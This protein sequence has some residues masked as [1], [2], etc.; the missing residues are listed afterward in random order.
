[1]SDREVAP[2]GAAEPAVAPE[3]SRGVLADVA[4]TIVDVA[5]PVIAAAR[6]VIDERPGARVRRVRRLS[7]QPLANL[8]DNHPET[9]RASIRELGL[10][11]VPIGEIR[12]TAVAGPAQR[13]GDFL[14]LRD[15]RG[16]DWHA[17]WQRILQANERLESLPPIELIKFDGGYWVVDGHNR[18]AAALY[19][20]Q[21]EMD[22]V[23]QELRLPGMPAETKPPIAAVL[24]GS[25]DLRAAG[26]GK[27]TK[28]ADR[29]L[30]LESARPH[31]HEHESRPSDE[32]SE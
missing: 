2:A 32:A 25:L 9:S 21:G 29:P 22:A 19:I 20:G 17:R 13:G 31:V 16:D 28:T 10:R 15:R 30:D 11:S 12:G 1:M 4:A 24:E 8:W 23:V 6:R 3:E 7:R 14:P 27:L 18:V 5:A 26:A